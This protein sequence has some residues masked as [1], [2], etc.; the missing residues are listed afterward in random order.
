M[1][2]MFNPPHPGEIL[3]DGVIDGGIS[4]TEF[5]DRLRVHRVT[6]SRLLNGDSDVSADMA[7]RLAKA[8]GDSAESWLHLQA[9]YDLWQ[10]EHRP[11]LKREVAKI[12]RLEEGV[13]A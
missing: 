11:D 9:A 3:R 2:R 8:L 12:E 10:A 6:L 13:A 4:V 7:V 5:A 1:T